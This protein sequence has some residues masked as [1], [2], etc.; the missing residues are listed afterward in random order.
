MKTKLLLLLT[1]SL[2]QLNQAFSQP[3][4]QV[5]TSPISYNFEDNV[6]EVYF[7]W[8]NSSY[9][10]VTKDYDIGVAIRNLSTEKIYM[11]RDVMASET[12]VT[13]PHNGQVSYSYNPKIDLTQYKDPSPLPGGTYEVAV[14]VDNYKKIDEGD[15]TNN[16]YFLY[17]TF[18]YEQTA[19][20]ISDLE[21]CN[22]LVY[23][24]PS[25]GVFKLSTGNTEVKSVE[26]YDMLGTLIYTQDEI[27]LTNEIDI[28]DFENGVYILN[29]RLN[30]QNISSR[31]IKR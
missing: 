29:V 31:I 12:G 5:H 8:T 30:N 17:G 7:Q 15:E 20:N 9:D 6:L 24:N 4:L 21:Q 25:N 13:I 1:V 28:S 23:P 19:T 27:I 22:L 10:P 2:L 3:D 16:A 14:V 26:I 11:V 18:Q